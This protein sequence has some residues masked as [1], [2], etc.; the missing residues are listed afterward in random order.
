MAVKGNLQD[1]SLTNLI[2]INCQSGITGQLLLEHDGEK[3]QIYFNTGAIVHAVYGAHSGKK[4]FYE[5][6]RWA[7]G[8]FDLE[9]DRAAPTQTITNHWSDLLLEGL[10]Q[11]DEQN[12]LEEEPEEIQS[13]VPDN[14][15]ALF[16]FEKS[17]NSKESDVVQNM[18]EIL[19]ELGRE[20]SGFTGSAIIGM[21]GLSIAEYSVN[22]SNAEAVNAQLTL[23]F[24]LVDTSVNKLD[25]G[26][27]QDFLLTTE[28]TY[29][30]I[31]YLSDNQYFLA[32]IGDRS[33]ANLGNMRLISRLYADRLSK[34]MPREITNEKTR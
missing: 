22:Q 23:L 5:L 29:T 2:Q 9:K 4:A 18:K 3:G 34:A 27:V 12:T 8:Q 19:I 24:K 14:I 25:A 13:V 20:V 32:I 7:D 30:L 26:I 21:D 28:K 1:I 15:G 11:L 6:L 33:K 16:G 10:R 17:S 31:R